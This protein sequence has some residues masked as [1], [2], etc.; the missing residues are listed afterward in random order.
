MVNAQLPV[1]ANDYP[2]LEQRLREGGRLYGFRSGGGL[3]ALSL[4]GSDP[5]SAWSLT[6]DEALQLLEGYLAGQECVAPHYLTGAAGAS[7]QMDEYLSSGRGNIEI[8]FDT[9]QKMF[10]SRVE[11]CDWDLHNLSLTRHATTMSGAIAKVLHG[12]YAMLVTED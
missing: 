12:Y 2:L 3:R 6:S 4:E 10:A 1:L 11:S 7:S 5:N 9:H 8:W